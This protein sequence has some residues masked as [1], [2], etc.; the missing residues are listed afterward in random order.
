MKNKSLR[1][2]N[3]L[4]QRYICQFIRILIPIARD[5]HHSMR[6]I[7]RWQIAL[8][9]WRWT[10]D[11]VDIRSGKVRKDAFKYNVDFRRHTQGARDALAASTSAKGL[12][13]EHMVPRSILADEIMK[14]D[15]DE[16]NIYHFLCKWCHAVI[17]T[18]KEDSQDPSENA[19]AR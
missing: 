2:L 18:K 9:M 13:H 19:N 11:A 12:R 7:A 8:A 14:R 4:E 6:G 1:P 5:D 16:N 17:V 3:K 15:M 10:A